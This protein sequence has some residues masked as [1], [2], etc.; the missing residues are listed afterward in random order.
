MGWQQEP[1]TA[2]GRSSWPQN[3]APLGKLAVAFNLRPLL[4]EQSLLVEAVLSH[5]HAHTNAQNTNSIHK[6][7]P[8]IQRAPF[9]SLC[10]LAGANRSAKAALPSCLGGCSV[11]MNKEPDLVFSSS[12]SLGPPAHREEQTT[13]PAACKEAPLSWQLCQR[14][15][16]MWPIV[17]TCAPTWP[18]CAFP[19]H[20]QAELENGGAPKE[21]QCAALDWQWQCK[22][23]WKWK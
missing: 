17:A 6:S 22:G 2:F 15:A 11:Q 9:V 12:V 23:K 19:A 10:W 7:R 20:F 21:W 8:I 13:F 16:P 5:T 4:F 18:A 3:S 14:G 1:K